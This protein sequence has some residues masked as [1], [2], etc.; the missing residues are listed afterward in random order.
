MT[1]SNPDCFPTSGTFPWNGQVW[2]IHGGASWVHNDMIHS[3]V[4]WSQMFTTINLYFLTSNLFSSGS[5][6]YLCMCVWSFW[7]EVEGKRHSQNILLSF[8]LL[9]TK[10]WQGREKW[11][12]R[13]TIECNFFLYALFHFFP[14][15]RV[16]EG[17]TIRREEVRLRWYFWFC[18]VVTFLTFT[19][20]KIFS[21]NREGARET[22]LVLGS[23]WGTLH[24]RE[25]MSSRGIRVSQDCMLSWYSTYAALIQLSPEEVN[26]NVIP[27]KSH[28]G[29][30]IS[31]FKDFSSHDVKSWFDITPYRVAIF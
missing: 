17:N 14:P 18:S 8:L 6:W 20:S 19:L 2:E 10:C 7:T 4:E 31:E 23:C 1:L 22:D 27:L 29:N 28:G 13:Y 5:L 25:G 30:F 21:R 16:P 11:E 15:P 9:E 3:R 12:Y 26:W 24:L